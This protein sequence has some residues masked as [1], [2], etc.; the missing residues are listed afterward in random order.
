MKRFRVGCSGWGYDDWVGPFYPPGTPAAEYLVRYSRVFD[1][2]GVSYGRADFGL[3]Q[4]K[5]QVYEINTNPEVAL[6][7]AHPSPV[8]LES[9]R[10]FKE[11]YLAAL[12]AIDTPASE[13]FVPIGRD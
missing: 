2:A 10:I 8:R 5:V 7:D 13:E 3:V 6:E 9:Y 1:L 4:G 12:S 11:N